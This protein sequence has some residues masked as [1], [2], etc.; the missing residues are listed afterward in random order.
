VIFRTICPEGVDHDVPQ[1]EQH[2]GLLYRSKLYVYL[3]IWN[4]GP[5]APLIGFNINLPT[6]ELR[7]HNT[8]ARAK[9]ATSKF[10]I[11]FIIIYVIVNML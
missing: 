6:K 4:C 2:L 5:I 11:T 1:V 7:S 8:I 10:V 3:F 9:C